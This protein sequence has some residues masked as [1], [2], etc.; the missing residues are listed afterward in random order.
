MSEIIYFTFLYYVVGAICVS[1]LAAGVMWSI[2][3]LAIT[4][5][6]YTPTGDW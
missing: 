5:G 1:G 2:P 4:Q 3:T 6:G